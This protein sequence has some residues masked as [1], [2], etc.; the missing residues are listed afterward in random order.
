MLENYEPETRTDIEELYN[1]RIAAF[2]VALNERITSTK[3]DLEF[4]RKQNEILRNEKNFL[5]MENYS[6]K[7]QLQLSYNRNRDLRI[8][9]LSLRKKYL[10]N[11]Q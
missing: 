5:E 3:S 6:I 1:E 10:L 11:N 4:E 2:N 9:N 8:E 7:R